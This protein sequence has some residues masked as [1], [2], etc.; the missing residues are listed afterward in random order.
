[1][2]MC[3]VYYFL[4]VCNIEDVTSSLPSQEIL[5]QNKINVI[6]LLLLYAEEWVS[7]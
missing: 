1:M 2:Y 5:L 6:H 7:K 4:F 3:G